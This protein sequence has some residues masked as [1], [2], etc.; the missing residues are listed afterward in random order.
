MSIDESAQSPRNEAFRGGD[1]VWVLSG[2]YAGH[3]CRVESSTGDD[4]VCMVRMTGERVSFRRDELT[5]DTSPLIP[6]DTFTTRLRWIL[7]FTVGLATLALLGH[8]ILTMAAM[9]SQP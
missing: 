1:R 3:R 9:T 7:V 2:E 5:R 4:V 8:N 6:P